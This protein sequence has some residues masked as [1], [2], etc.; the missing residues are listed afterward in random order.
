MSLNV[1]FDPKNQTEMDKNSKC[2]EA[3]RWKVDKEVSPLLT[4][5]ILPPRYAPIHR[6]MAVK[7]KYIERI[8]TIGPHRPLWARYGEYLYVPPQRW[9]HNVEHGAIIVLYHPCADHDEVTL[10]F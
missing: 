5:V 10:T 8:P 1:D 9:L 3:E 6:C 7:I 4:I 2:I